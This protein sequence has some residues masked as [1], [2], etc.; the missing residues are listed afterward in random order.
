[1]NNDIF[2]YRSSY[3]GRV[4]DCPINVFTRREAVAREEILLKKKIVFGREYTYAEPK[5][6]GSYAFGGTILFTSNGNFPEFT[7][8]IKLHDRDMSKETE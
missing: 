2:I 5:T 3:N 8:P 6:P 4:D 7:T 1:M